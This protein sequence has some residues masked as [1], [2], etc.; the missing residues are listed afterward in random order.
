MPISDLRLTRDGVCRTFKLAPEMLQQLEGA[1]VLVPDGDHMFDVGGVAAALFH[2]GMSRSADADR[3]LAAVGTSLQDVLPA[4]QRLAGLPDH[5]ALEG[6]VREKVTA[7]LS[8]FFNAFAA[9][10]GQATAVLREGEEP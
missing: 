5:L 8:T 6:E 3:K 9:L 2:F 10:L 7:E 4:L 1:G